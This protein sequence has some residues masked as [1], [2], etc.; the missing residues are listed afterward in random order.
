MTHNLNAVKREIKGEKI[1][2]EGKLPAVIYGAGGTSESLAIEYTEFAKLHNVASESSLI[3]LI[4][5]GKSAGKVLVQ[6]IQADPVS[7]RFVHVDLR[8]IDMAKPIT[9]HVELKFVGESQAI[10]GLGGTLVHAIYE[11]E[12]KCLPKDLIPYLEVDISVLQTFNDMIKIKDLSLPVGVV[13]TSPHAEDM[14]AK[15]TPALTED[16]IKKMEEESK[17]ADVSKIETAGKKKEE[18]EAVEGVGEAG[19]DKAA[20]ADKKVEEKK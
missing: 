1:R 19:A 11:V 7:G 4:I 6:D 15:A 20:P 17:V 8:R 9:T 18:E 3:D 5:D 13:I 10:K 12:V 14:V 16:E 2:A